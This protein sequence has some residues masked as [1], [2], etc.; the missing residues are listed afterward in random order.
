MRLDKRVGIY[1]VLWPCLWS[2]AISVKNSFPYIIYALFIAGAIVMRGAGCIINDIIDRKI[3]AEVRRTKNRPIA[4]G[5]VKVRSA[6]IFLLFLL[7][8]GALILSYFNKTTQLLGVAVLLPIFI[9]P[10][11]KR[12]TYWPQAFLAIIFNWG[13]LMG[14]A[15]IHDKI[16]TT[17]LILY[18]ACFFWTLGYDT[19]YAHQD[20]ESDALIGV[21]STALKLGKYTKKYLYAFYS[22][23]V[24]CLWAAGVSADLG[25]A[26]HAF[27]II[28]T[29]HLLWQVYEVNLDRPIDCL[30]KFHSNVYFG[31]IILIGIIS[32]Y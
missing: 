7:A 32:G 12:I 11:M 19:I 6:V 25:I 9:Y 18:A 29:L 22:I 4:S 13:A 17:S 15:A 3:D 30:R 31:L 2:I 24:V 28:G 27:L 10:F 8:I 20:K 1:L 23:T 21:K 26:Y 5:R 14:A 16:T